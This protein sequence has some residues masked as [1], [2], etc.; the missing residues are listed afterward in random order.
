MSKVVLQ[1]IFV[2][3]HAA[4]F[5]VTIIIVGRVIITSYAYDFRHASFGLRQCLTAKG[6][7]AVRFVGQYS[8]A[9]EAT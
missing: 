2:V 7:H 3:T 1:C 6:K 9:Q 5:I 8:V 4:N